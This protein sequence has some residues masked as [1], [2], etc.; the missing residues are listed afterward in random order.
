[1]ISLLRDIKEK[2]A[3]LLDLIGPEDAQSKYLTY[4]VFHSK[5]DTLIKRIKN[6]TTKFY[7]EEETRVLVSTLKR[8]TTP[9]MLD[10]G[11]NIGLMSLNIKSFIEQ[12]KIYAFEPGPNQFKYLKKN[13]E[14]NHLTNDVSVFNVALGDSNESINFFIHE[15]KNSSGDGMLDT[16][17]AGKGV[18]V[19]VQSRMLDTWWREQSMPMIGLIKIDTEGAELLI[20]RNA[21]NVIQTCRPLMLIEIC[22]LNFEKYGFTFA[23][24]IE[25]FLG[26]QYEL[27]DIITKSKVQNNSTVWMKHFYYLAIPDEKYE[28]FK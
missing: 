19:K 5:K 22:Y 16:G 2:G 8:T 20:L 3:E 14:K 26:Q 24:H 11:A 15:S 25:F 7:E 21:I 28:F 1:M 12:V 17:R 9:V 13:I 4:N 18:N 10:I 23:D 27:Y 6:S